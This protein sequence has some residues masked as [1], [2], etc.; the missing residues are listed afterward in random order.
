MPTVCIQQHAKAKST[1]SNLEDTMN[2]IVKGTLFHQTSVSLIVLLIFNSTE[3]N[4]V[5]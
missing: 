3:P 5:C 1:V 2:T 4:T